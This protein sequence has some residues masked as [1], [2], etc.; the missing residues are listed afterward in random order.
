MTTVLAEMT[1]L[2]LA[3]ASFAVKFLVA[4]MAPSSLDLNLQTDRRAVMFFPVTNG[5]ICG[6]LFRFSIRWR[7][8]ARAKSDQVDAY[9]ALAR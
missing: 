7:I 3:G 5:A 6:P 2:P 4:F 1:Q 8:L 9:P